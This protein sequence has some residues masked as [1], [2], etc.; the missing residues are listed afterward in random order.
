MRTRIKIKR[1]IVNSADLPTLLLGA[2]IIF[3]YCFTHYHF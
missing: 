3:I 1:K 2:V